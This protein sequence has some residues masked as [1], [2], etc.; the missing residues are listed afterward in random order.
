MDKLE[1]QNPHELD[2][3]I[4]FDE[5]P[6][7][8]TIKGNSN[9]LSVTTWNKSMFEKFDAD[10]VIENMMK[11]S[12]WPDSKYFNM[13]KEEI[14]K[15]WKDNG[16]EASSS[17]TKMHANIEKFYNGLE[18]RDESVEYEY[19]L[20]FYEDHKD[21]Y[22]AYRTEWMIYDEELEFAGSID[23]VFKDKDGNICLGDWKRSKEIKK[24]AFGNKCST[25]PLIDHIPDSNYWHYSLQLNTYKAILEKNYSVKIK[26]LFI[27]CL[28]PENKNNSYM[29]FKI[30]DLQEEVKVLF[31]ERKKQ[32][33]K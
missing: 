32:L 22:T 4:T 20:S 13:T 31:K 24:T 33:N 27:I 12:K 26:D 19:F 28:H 3:H 5:A 29:K 14:K 15:S 21:I 10:K 6:H 16:Q 25:N 11:S 1:K 9:F 18:V 17:G 7:I 23:I 2:Q 30:P 8:Y